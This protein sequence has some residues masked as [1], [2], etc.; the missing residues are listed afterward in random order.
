MLFHY[1][2]GDYMPS[3]EANKQLKDAITRMEALTGIVASEIAKHRAAGRHTLADKLQKELDR[4]RLEI[5]QMR[6]AYGI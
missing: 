6:R 1:M 2:I 4:K 3:E 5:Q